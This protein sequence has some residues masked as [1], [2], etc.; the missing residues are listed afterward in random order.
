MVTNASGHPLAGTVKT[1]FA[2]AGQVVGHETPPTHPLS[3]GRLHDT[4][5]FPAASAG[6]P[7]ALQTVV[8]TSLGSITL[9]W[10][11]TPTR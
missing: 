11:V 10:P 6:E 1:E 9:T 4:V 2:F 3:N 5:E 8:H 7:L